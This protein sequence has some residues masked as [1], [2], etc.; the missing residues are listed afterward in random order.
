MMYIVHSEYFGH[1]TFTSYERPSSSSSS[2]VDMTVY[3]ISQVTATFIIFQ[4]QTKSA[5]SNF[6]HKSFLRFVKIW[7]IDIW[8]FCNNSNKSY[9]YRFTRNHVCETLIFGIYAFL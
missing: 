1:R 9:K 7:M 4:I 6:E 5:V 8:P 2:S 3:M